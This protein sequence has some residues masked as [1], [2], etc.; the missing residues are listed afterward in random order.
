MPR[1]AS[2]SACARL[3]PPQSGQWSSRAWAGGVARSSKPRIDIAVAPLEDIPAR[4]VARTIG[5][6]DFV[7]AMRA[8]HPF[9]AIADAGALLRDAASRRLAD[10]RFA[11]GFVDDASPG[12]ASP[13]GSR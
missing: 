10:R 4:F 1:P 5:E 7:I 9:A 13:G 12:R 2:T 11:Y 6:E 3:L 8:G